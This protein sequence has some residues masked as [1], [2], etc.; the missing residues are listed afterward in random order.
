MKMEV[1]G[2]GCGTKLVMV[3]EKSRMKPRFLT[4]SEI[5]YGEAIKLK[6][7]QG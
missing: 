4:E 2:Q 6:M 5:G 3:R 1:A 7:E